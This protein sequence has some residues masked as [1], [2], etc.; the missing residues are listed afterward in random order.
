RFSREKHDASFPRRAALF[1]LG[2]AGLSVR[3]LDHVVFAEKPSR[4]FERLLAE[5]MTSF[6]R[7]WRSFPKVLFPWLG[8][9]LWVRGRICDE[10][11]VDPERVLFVESQRARAGNAFFASP[12]EEAAVLV[13]DEALEWAATTLAR[14]RGNELDVLGEIHHPHSLGL[15]AATASERLGLGGAEGFG[16]LFALASSGKP[17]RA[18]EISAAVHPAEDGS[19]ELDL[20]RLGEALGPARAAGAPLKWT[21][22]DR[23]H[24]DLAASVVLAVGDGLLHVARELHRRVPSE[25]LCFGGALAGCAELNA[26]LAAEGPFRRLF[27][28]PAPGDAGAA[29]GA[30]LVVAHALGRP[31]RSPLAHAFLGEAVAPEGEHAGVVERL[32]EALAQGRTVGWARGRFEWGAR[33]LGN[34]SILAREKIAASV[35]RREAYFPSCCAVPAERAGEFYE[36]Q[37]G[38]EAL[39]PFLHVAAPAR[40]GAVDPNARPQLVDRRTDPAFHELL[41]QFGERTGVPV[42]VNTSLN[43]RGDPIARGEADAV[44]VFE[45]SGLHVLAIEGEIRERD[46]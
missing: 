41:V 20:E 9:R 13:A 19:F 24:A 5:E 35:K 30:A 34:R 4:R 14:G 16:R 38:T 26:R 11:G 44:A 25:N 40:S 18:G 31:A 3:D 1:C 36:L 6:P 37:S 32:A 15:L 2:E 7:S 12:F 29:L 8:D 27:V 43:L 17:T 46:A 21:G 22:A 10:L 39:A 45:R 42:L 28:P 23:T 33:S